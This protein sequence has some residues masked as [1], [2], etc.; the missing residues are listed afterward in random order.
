MQGPIA[1]NL[2]AAGHAQDGGGVVST[3]VR[4]RGAP[5]ALD[6][7]GFTSLF[8]E[9]ALAIR[10]L[11]LRMGLRGDDVVDAHTEAFMILR[12]EMRTEG[13]PDNV[14]G[15]LVTIAVKV[16]QNKLRVL[17]SKKRRGRRASGDEAEALPS[18]WRSPESQAKGAEE[19]QMVH[20]ALD[21]MPDDQ[22][23]F[24]RAIDLG[25]ASHDEV[26]AAL[27]TTPE[28]LRVQLFRARRKLARVLRERFGVDLGENP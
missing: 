28:N 19:A 17:R 10:G 21:L 24:I 12:D 18:S 23:L 2:G 26:A 13:V 25:G 22:A 7:A 16:I 6:E 9:H 11:V 8:R 15:K 27:G 3:G 5:V 1:K 4:T 20:A 14:R